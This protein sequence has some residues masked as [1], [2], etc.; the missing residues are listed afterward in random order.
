VFAQLYPTRKWVQLSHH[1]CGE[2]NLLIDAQA[3]C[4][5]VDSFLVCPHFPHL[6][7]LFSFFNHFFFLASDGKRML[8]FGGMNCKRSFTRLLPQVL[9]GCFVCSRSSRSQAVVC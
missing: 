1:L 7:F 2:Y 8:L 9:W 5:Q 6:F 3:L 4:S